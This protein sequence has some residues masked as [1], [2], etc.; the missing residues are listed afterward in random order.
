M[1]EPTMYISYRPNVLQC[2]EDLENLK[3][4]QCVQINRRDRATP[5]DCRCL[6]IGVALQVIYFCAESAGH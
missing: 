5:I 4:G 1:P 3:G 6:N 2:A